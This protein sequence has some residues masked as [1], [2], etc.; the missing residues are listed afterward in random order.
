MLYSYKVI[1][2][3]GF[4]LSWFVSWLIK[5]KVLRMNLHEMVN[6]IRQIFYLFVLAG[7]MARKKA[8]QRRS[9]RARRRENH[10]VGG[11]V[12]PFSYTVSPSG[13]ETIQGWTKAGRFCPRQY[14][15]SDYNWR[16]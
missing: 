14:L 1:R 5:R 11:L 9:D 10:P 6:R 3:L 16:G 4:L 8:L 12:E 7:E 13:R 15:H 2:V